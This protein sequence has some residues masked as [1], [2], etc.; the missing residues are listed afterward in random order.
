MEDT[1][2]A[3]I[4]KNRDE[5]IRIGLS[6]YKGHHL[7]FMRVF[8]EPYADTGQGR[9]PTKK[10]I[11]FAVRLLPNIINALQETERRAREAGL[12]KEEGEAA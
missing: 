7:A 11:T 6:E 2:F 12:L 10:G 3:T 1:T 4:P 5:E 9:V 8:T